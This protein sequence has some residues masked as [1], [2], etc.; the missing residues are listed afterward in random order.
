MAYIEWWN[1]TG[2]ITM[3]ERFGLNEI[4]TARNTLSPTK[5]YTEGGRIALG[6]GTNFRGPGKIPPGF[7]SRAELAKLLDIE[8]GTIMSSKLR[9]KKGGHGQTLYK[10]ITDILKVKQ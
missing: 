1:R 8:P 7:I 10:N 9:G 3:G 5:S 6:D 2:P 4:S